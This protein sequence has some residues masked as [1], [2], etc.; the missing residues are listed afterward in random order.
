MWKPSKWAIF[1]KTILALKLSCLFYLT[2]EYLSQS[3]NH[4]SDTQQHPRL[5][6]I[7]QIFQFTTEVSN[8]NVKLSLS[9]AD[10]LHIL[11]GILK[12]FEP[13]Y[14]RPKTQRSCLPRV[15]HWNPW[16]YSKYIKNVTILLLR[17]AKKNSQ[18]SFFFT[19][20]V[21]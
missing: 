13:I 5:Y 8:Y 21:K 1:W 9:F 6:L 17:V 4:L 12:L 11:S 3:A 18:T 16:F 10:S 15:I 7:I 20:I 19:F 14:A 2:S